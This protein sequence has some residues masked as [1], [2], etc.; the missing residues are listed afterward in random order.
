MMR[1][2]SLTAASCTAK[3]QL[4]RGQRGDDGGD[5]GDRSSWPEQTRPIRT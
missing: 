3:L 4:D 2:L 1:T 5:G